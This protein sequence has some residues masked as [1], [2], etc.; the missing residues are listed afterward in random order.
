MHGV[1]NY[2]ALARDATTVAD[3]LDLRV[4]EQTHQS[5]MTPRWLYGSGGVIASSTEAESLPMLP[6]KPRRRRCLGC[7]RC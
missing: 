3:L 6:A 5:T 7:A 1:R 2:S 4:D